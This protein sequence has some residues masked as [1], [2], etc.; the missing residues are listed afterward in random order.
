MRDV[1][2]TACKSNYDFTLLAMVRGHTASLSSPAAAAP[3]SKACMRPRSV[4]NSKRHPAA[5][6]SREQQTHLLDAMLSQAQPAA[7]PVASGPEVQH[8][9]AGARA[10]CCQSNTACRTGTNG[11][12]LH[13]LNIEH[14][15]SAPCMD[16][17]AGAAPTAPPAGGASSAPQEPLDP[18]ACPSCSGG[19][20]SSCTLCSDPSLGLGAGT[21]L[22]PSGRASARTATIALRT[23]TWT[24]SC[25]SGAGG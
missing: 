1:A 16:P 5:S 6:V 7:A 11:G 3:Y 15:R 14:M 23:R 24:R 2:A 4:C 21:G 12:K 8:L 17:P 18:Y 25:T 13:V 9:W 10:C 20:N 22:A 19:A